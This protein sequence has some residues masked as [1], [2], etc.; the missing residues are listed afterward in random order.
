MTAKAKKTG[1]VEKRVKVKLGGYNAIHA[2][3]VQKIQ[4]RQ[5]DIEY[6]TIELNTFR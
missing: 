2:S 1:K 6:T 3:L 4:D 5:Q